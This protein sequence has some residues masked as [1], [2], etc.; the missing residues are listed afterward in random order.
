MI[1]NE[2]DVI[3]HDCVVGYPKV[4]VNNDTRYF[5]PQCGKF[6]PLKVLIL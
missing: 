2:N 4:I 5:Y 3:N 1:V 6:I